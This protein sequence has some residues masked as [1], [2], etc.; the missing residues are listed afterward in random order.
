MPRI[1]DGNNRSQTRKRL[2]GHDLKIG[3][4]NV[5]T[6][7]R[8]GKMNEIASEMMKNNLDIIA[9]QEIRWMG[10]GKINKP[11]FSIYYSGDNFRSGMCGTEEANDDEK[12]EFYEELNNLC[13]GIPDYDTLIIAGDLNAKIGRE[14]CIQQVAGRFSLHNETN[15]NGRRLYQFANENNLRIRS[16]AFER[17][18]IHKGTWKVPERNVVNQIDHVLISKRWATSIIDVRT[19]KGANCDSN[20]FLV[21]SKL[22][23]RISNVVKQKG[24]KRRKWNTDNL[25]NEGTNEN[26]RNIVERRLEGEINNARSIDE[27][28]DQMENAMRRTAEEIVG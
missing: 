15:E 14:R 5:Q 13:E 11:D 21:V 17:K 7:M 18:N 8:P 26:F 12:D 1:Y 6:T 25:K 2:K 28:W 10:Y 9:L 16:T 24:V 4:W 27:E 19:Y 22:R 20:H 23:Q 3:T